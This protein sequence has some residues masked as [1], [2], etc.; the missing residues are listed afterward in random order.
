MS[1]QDCTPGFYNF[2]DTG[3]TA[4][5]CGIG[6]TNISCDQSEGYCYCQSGAGGDKC[7]Q[8]L[9]FR[10]NLLSSGCTLCNACTEQL[11]H[12][13]MYI[14]DNDLVSLLDKLSTLLVLSS[15][16]ERLLSSHQSMFRPVSEA[17]RDYRSDIEEY[18]DTIRGINAGGLNYSLGIK[19]FFSEISEELG[20][21]SPI[22]DIEFSRIR[23]IALDVLAYKDQLQLEIIT[24]VQDLADQLIIS[25]SALLLAG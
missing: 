14:Q 25:D 21:L 5:Q 9:P 4:C 16:G 11:G 20:M 10:E 8:C 13:A 17:V 2:S 24:L 15:D 12:M 3:C 7:D 1:R 23:G 22:S 19:R 6:A 18:R